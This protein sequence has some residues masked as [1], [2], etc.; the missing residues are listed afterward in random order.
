VGLWYVRHYLVFISVAPLLVGF[1]GLGKGSLARQIVLGVGMTLAAALAFNSSL[2]QNALGEMLGTFD[3]ASDA[4]IRQENQ[5]GA[6]GV[7]F[8]DGGRAFGAIHLKILYTLFSPFPWQGGSFAMQMGKLDTLVWYYL[9]SRLL[10][11]SA[12]LWRLDRSIFFMFLVFLVP[13][14]IAYATTMANI[15]L[16]LRQRFP[17]VFIGA[18]LGMLS[19]PATPGWAAMNTGKLRA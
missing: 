13:L 10:R 3:H 19:W 14:T 16:I 8:D 2:G 6:S 15:G 12:R 17:I 11:S 5:H 4:N 18:M 9:F 1:V 7:A